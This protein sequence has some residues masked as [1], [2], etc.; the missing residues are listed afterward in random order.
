MESTF[1][2]EVADQICDRVMNGESSRAICE[3]QGMPTW[4]TLFRWL[5]ANEAFRQ[6]YARAKEIAGERMAEDIISIAD[7]ADSESYNAARLQVD[8]RKWIMSK[9]LPKKYGDATLLKHADPDGNA[10]K[11]EVTR[12]SGKE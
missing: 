4:R 5:D 11:V 6:Q 1:T 9:L 10:L 8:A 12:I 3:A 2:Q 7:S